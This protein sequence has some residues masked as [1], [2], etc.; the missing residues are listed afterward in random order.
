MGE[1]VKFI[2]I[3]CVH[4]GHAGGENNRI[5]FHWE[6]SFIFMQI[7]FIVCSSNMAATNALYTL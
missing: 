3:E 2:S 1:H 6:K 5:R 7:D 4:S